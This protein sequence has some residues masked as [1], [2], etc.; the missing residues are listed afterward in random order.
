[1]CCYSNEPSLYG[2]YFL[3]FTEGLSL[4]IQV[5]SGIQNTNFADSL[6]HPFRIDQS[7]AEWSNT[8]QIPSAG[9]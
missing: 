8:E 3:E 1:M 4:R 5:E 6:L 9:V 2:I 7:Y